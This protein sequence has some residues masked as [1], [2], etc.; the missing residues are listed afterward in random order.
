MILS[1]KFNQ[2]FQCISNKKMLLSLEQL[3]HQINS[4]TTFSCKAPNTSQ[5]CEI[6]SSSN[7]IVHDHGTFTWLLLQHC[8]SQTLIILVKK[9]TTT[10]KLHLYESVLTLPNME[11]S[12]WCFQRQKVYFLASF[13]LYL[14]D[15]NTTRK[16][17]ICDI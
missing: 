10:S 7:K 14:A 3:S 6:N 4:I 13:K 15:P 8:S 12:Q 2:V 16:H 17:V 1:H 11:D 9:I 5:I